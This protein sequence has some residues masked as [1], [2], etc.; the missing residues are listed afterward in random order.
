MPDEES[1]AVI[2]TGIEFRREGVPIAELVDIDGPGIQRPDVDVTHQRSGDA[3]DSIP[4]TTNS[5]EV[6]IDC[7]M[8]NGDA[9]QQ[10]VMDDMYTRDKHNYSIL[11]PENADG[12]TEVWS[13]KGYPKKFQPKGKRGDKLALNI[14]FKVTGKIT[15]S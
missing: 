2:A 10:Q 9:S 15:R 4:G 11:W 14:V 8:L 13:F 5:G 7:N 6:T 12:E 3:D 1:Q